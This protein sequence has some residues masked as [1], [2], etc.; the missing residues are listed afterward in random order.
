[1]P[2][3]G[4]KNAE[5]NIISMCYLRVFGCRARILHAREHVRFPG[6]GVHPSCVGF[7]L[8]LALL[9]HGVR[10]GL[11][12]PALAMEKFRSFLAELSERR[13]LAELR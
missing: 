1:M 4:N 10:L 9:I 5:A 13:H 6:R 3:G 7:T 8:L 2:K 11:G 12:Y